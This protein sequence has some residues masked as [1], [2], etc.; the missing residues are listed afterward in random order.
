MM[1]QAKWL[2]FAFFMLICIGTAG[3]SIPGMITSGEMTILDA[4]FTA[5]SAVCV[6][7]LTVVD[8]EQD[9]TFWEQFVILILIQCGGIG[10]ITIA[11]SLIL[12]SH[13]RLS[14]EYEG[15]LNSTV[16]V[17]SQITFREITYSVIKFTLIIEGI[18]ALLLLLFWHPE[19]AFLTRCWQSLFHS[20]SAF[21]NAGFSV[22]SRNLEGFTHHYGVNIVIMGLVMLGG[23]GFVNLRELVT[24][25]RA[26]KFR[27]RYFSLFLKVGLM[28]TVVLNVFGTVLI[29]F[30]D[31]HVALSE[32]SF[33][34]QCSAAAFHAVSTRTAGFNTIPIANFTEISL[35]VMILYMFIGGISGSCAGGVKVNSL[36]VMIS[37]IHA[38]IR[39]SEHP[40]L[41]NRRLSNIT[42]RRAITLFFCS[43]VFI[44]LSVCG[45]YIT[46]GKL[47]GHTIRQPHFLAYLFEM[48]SALGTVGLSAGITATLTVMSK[49]LVI[50]LM[51]IGRLGPLV[52]ISA[53]MGEPTPKPFTHPEESLPVG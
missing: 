4:C 6:T 52:V 25:F 32:L 47:S 40:V 13:N 53:W 33:F 34:E 10:I 30:A 31:R 2:I 22:F 15:M 39:N 48:T 42:Q 28:G 9:F 7:G 3:L 16:A 14:L 49:C 38:Y 43:L 8:T 12:S 21:C 18:G 1:S 11:S 23:F 51:F 20:I 41:F 37:I 29:F 5:T 19:D 24:K 45:G 50:V 35:F 17:S 46:E 27:W 26:K 44:S 36:T